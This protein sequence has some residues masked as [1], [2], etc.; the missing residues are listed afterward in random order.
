MSRVK[1]ILAP[2]F[3]KT[4]PARLLPRA[5]HPGPTR[6]KKRTARREPGAVRCS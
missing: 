6:K 4:P 5:W 1:L 2:R 3:V